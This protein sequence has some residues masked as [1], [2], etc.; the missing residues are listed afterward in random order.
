MACDTLLDHVAVPPAN[1]HRMPTGQAD[2]VAAAAAYE[3]QLRTH[4]ETT[5]PRFDIVLLGLGQDGHTASLFPGSPAL[6]EAERWVVA[7]AG[8]TEPRTRLT[9]TLPAIIHAASINVVASGASKAD[10][11]RQA[12]TAEP[13][14]R[15]CPASAIRRTEGA[16]TWWADEAAAALVQ[17]LR[18]RKGI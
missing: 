2:P 9:L 16:L 1:V 15:T 18:N 11:L 6:D 8:P 4:F 3:E 10:A 13:D 14:Y 7:V 17:P 12:L 5:W